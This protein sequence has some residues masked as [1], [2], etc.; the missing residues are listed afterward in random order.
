MT[1][2]RPRLR[3]PPPRSSSSASLVGPASALPAPARAGTLDP[4]APLGRRRA[5]PLRLDPFRKVA[6]GTRRP[7]T[8]GARRPRRRPR[9]AAPR[10]RRRAAS[11]TRTA[12]ARTSAS[13]T[14]ASRSSCAPTSST[15]TTAR[16]PS[17]RSSASTGRSAGSTGYRVVAPF[18]W[19]FWSPTTDTRSSR[20]S[21]GGSRTRAQAQPSS[22]GT[23]P[24]SAGSHGRD[25]QLVRR[26]AALLR[27]DHASAGRCR[28]SARCAIHDPETPELLRR[29]GLPLL[30]A[31]LADALDRS[32]VPALRLVPHGRQRLHLRAAAELLLAERATTRACWRCRSSTANSHKTGS[33]FSTWLGYTHREGPEYGRSLA[34]A[35]LVGRRREGAVELPRP[36]PAGLGLRGEGERHHGRLPAGLE[37]PQP[38]ARTPPSSVPFVHVREGTWYF[39]TL[40]PLWWSGGD[41]KTRRAHRLLVPFFYWDRAR[42]RPGDATW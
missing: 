3:E 6:G 10:R 9:H 37:L 20:R 22:P 24:S 2:T 14:S 7:T 5:E 12:P 21:T 18:Y 31:A 27:V 19:H 30:V 29:G 15:S 42:A 17:A 16:A 33:C 35:L 25:A 38:G 28:S 11:A 41:D 32:R 36:L 4:F 1:G 39:N 26:L 8:A 40:L 23:G 13:P 34:L